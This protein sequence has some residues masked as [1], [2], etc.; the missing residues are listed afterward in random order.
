MK[1][2][3]VSNQSQQ[4]HCIDLPGES[5]QCWRSSDN[6]KILMRKH[7]DVIFDLHL[8]GQRRYTLHT[9]MSDFYNQRDK[10]IMLALRNEYIE[11]GD[12]ERLHVWVPRGFKGSLVL[13]SEGRV[14]M[15]VK[16]NDM[17]R[18]VHGDDPITKPPPI[19]VGLGNPAKTPQV[20]KSQ[21]G[22]LRPNPLSAVPAS[23]SSPTRAAAP[24]D[25]ECGVTC[26]VDGALN[27]APSSLLKHLSKGGGK[28]GFADLDIN[29]VAT[30]NWIY[31]QGMGTVGFIYDNWQWLRASID[32]KTH[33]GLRLVSVKATYVRGT[34]RFYFSGY[35]KFNTIFGRGGFGAGHNH[36]LTIL[37]G[38]GKTSSTFKSA[39]KAVRGSFG[40]FAAFAFVFG[41]VTAWAEWRDDASKDSADFWAAFFM[42]LLKTII[43]AVL[44]T[45]A[46]ALLVLAISIVSTAA[47]PVLAIGAV[48]V[49][50]SFGFNYLVEAADKELGRKVTG[51]VK[52]T[53]G[54]SAAIAPHL[55]QAFKDIRENWNY[56]MA[57]FPNDYKE[58]SF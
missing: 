5:V 23:H 30:R 1:P 13:K 15:E 57:K 54:L 56:L 12:A 17:D 19:I 39:L 9:T 3:A 32:A 53:D 37:G 25:E 51:D 47:I 24:V 20:S 50:L 21:P 28:S 18:A 41:T 27:G 38:A 34:I 36:I 14:L 22:V 43:V 7:R 4:L 58:I 55:R 45:A 6:L 40:G 2:Q 35:S 8:G 44:V 16:P 31:G 29:D 42:S 26:V 48:T 10:T 49:A 33:Q 46:V 11:F 52:N